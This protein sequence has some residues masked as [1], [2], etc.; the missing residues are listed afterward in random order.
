[1]A[2]N[3][4]AMNMPIQTSEPQMNWLPEEPDALLNFTKPDEAPN[5][6]QVID[7]LDSIVTSCRIYL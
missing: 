6:D 1:M 7:R 2:N 3:N 4:I 5:T